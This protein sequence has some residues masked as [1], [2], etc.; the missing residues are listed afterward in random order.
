MFE[1]SQINKVSSSVI[2]DKKSVKHICH[3]F[4]E[5]KRSSIVKMREKSGKEE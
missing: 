2:K 1:V 5:C 4:L 3:A